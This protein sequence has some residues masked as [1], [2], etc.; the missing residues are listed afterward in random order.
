MREG[1]DYGIFILIADA[2]AYSARPWFWRWPHR[3][4][5]GGHGPSRSAVSF[6]PC[7]WRLG[8]LAGPRHRQASRTPKDVGPNK[9]FDWQL[10][11][12]RRAA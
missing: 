2:S 11:C 12:A 8:V 5:R 9:V 1:S 7:R 4:R 10:S 6:L 3:G